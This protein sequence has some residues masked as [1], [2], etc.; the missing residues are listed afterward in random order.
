MRAANDG[1]GQALA[2]GLD[3]DHIRFQELNLRTGR[4]PG[5][6]P[7]LAVHQGPAGG[8]DEVGHQGPAVHRGPAGPADR[9]PVDMPRIV[10]LVPRRRTGLPGYQVEDL[11]KNHVVYG[12]PCY[13]HPNV[14]SSLHSA[15][16]LEVPNTPALQCTSCSP[17]PHSAGTIDHVI[18]GS[19]ARQKIHPGGRRCFEHP[20]HSAIPFT[21]HS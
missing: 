21:A 6:P 1:A 4:R 16:G 2:A 9:L 12:V 5:R 18:N 7:R 14:N 10:V 15:N 13:I 3:D 8:R 20:W 11:V 19:A 17:S